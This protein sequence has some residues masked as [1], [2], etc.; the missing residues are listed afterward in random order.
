MIEIQ[1]LALA[2]IT[3]LVPFALAHPAFPATMEENLQTCKKVGQLAESIMNARQ[4]GATPSKMIEVV[5]TP[6]M[7]EDAKSLIM[8]MITNAFDEPR[9]NSPKFITRSVQDFRSKAE[10]EC[11]SVVMK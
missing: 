8:K 1:K 5:I 10:S 3:S 4:A 9:Y 6:T 2:F 11:L 7:E